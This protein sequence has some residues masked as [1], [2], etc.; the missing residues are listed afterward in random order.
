MAWW[1]KAL[2]YS[3]TWFIFVVVFVLVSAQWTPDPST[4]DMT[5]KV[6]S[7]L[8]G[9]FSVTISNMSD[10][11]RSRLL[12]EVAVYLLAFGIAIIWYRAYKKQP[13]K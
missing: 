6:N 13:D 12:G 8:P 7:G 4:S 1:K 2:V 10:K 5:Y 3:A 11:E 9:D